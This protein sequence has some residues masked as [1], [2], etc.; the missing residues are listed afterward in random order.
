MGLP[1]V[2]LDTQFPSNPKVLELI[3]R[4]QHQAAFS[5]LCSLAYAGQ[6][7]TDGF[8]PETALPFIHA[9]KSVANHLVAVGLW[10]LSPGGWV[11]NGWNEFQPSTEETIR[12]RE[13]AQKGAAAR[14]ATSKKGQLRGI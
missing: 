3:V 1:W 5:Y 14:W 13:R 10:E 6:H 8:I 12:R 11:I 9:T 2:R 4:K 7:G